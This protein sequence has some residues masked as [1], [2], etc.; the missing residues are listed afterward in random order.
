MRVITAMTTHMRSG[1]PTGLLVKNVSYKVQVFYIL[2][3]KTDNLRRQATPLPGRHE[4][5]FP[6]L[7][8]RLQPPA[9]PSPRGPLPRLRPA[10]SPVI[11]AAMTLTS[12]SVVSNALRRRRAEV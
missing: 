4:P 2:Y 12:V 5:C 7:R 6:A 11:A 8:L 3:D 10:F 9:S 1:V